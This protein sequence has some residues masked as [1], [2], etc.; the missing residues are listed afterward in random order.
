M[1]LVLSPKLSFQVYMQPLVPVGDYEN[2]KELARPRSYE[3]TRFGVDRGVIEYEAGAREYV[4]APGDGGATF[5]FFKSFRLNAIFRWE[6][7][8][9]SAM[10]VVW[11]EQRED[12]AYPGQFT[13][14]R[15]FGRLFGAAA[16]DV[17]MFKL[18]Y[19]LSR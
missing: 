9:G 12:L 6:W 2:F 11:T 13:F 16:D 17:I 4:V 15:D 1:N 18:V 14:R 5:R 10:Y 7:R 3:F 19:W 8:P